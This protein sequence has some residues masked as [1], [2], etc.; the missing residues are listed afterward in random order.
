MKA[1]DRQY[2]KGI[3]MQFQRFFPIFATNLILNN[4]IS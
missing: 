4:F 2:F 3:V 1:K